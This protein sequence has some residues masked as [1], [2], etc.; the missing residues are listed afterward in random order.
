[1]IIPRQPLPRRTVLRGLGATMALPLFEAM[2]ANARAADIA[3]RT[4]R[5]Q[6][7]YTPNG[8][9]M[10]SFR[11][12]NPGKLALPAT[13]EPLAPYADQVTAAKLALTGRSEVKVIYLEI[14]PETAG[15]PA[16]HVAANS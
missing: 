13:L 8:M 10:P 15:G 11:P 7:F 4:K 12:S 2:I 16:P 5:L 6:I 9:M 3:A 1:M 14:F